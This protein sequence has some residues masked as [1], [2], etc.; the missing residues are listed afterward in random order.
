L[1]NADRLFEAPVIVDEG[2][3]PGTPTDALTLAISR[4]Q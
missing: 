1:I 4:T 3:T 2:Q